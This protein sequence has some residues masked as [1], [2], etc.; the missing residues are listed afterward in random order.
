M[1]FL[2]DFHRVARLL[3]GKRC[4][5][6]W[7]A[8]LYTYPPKNHYVANIY[9]KTDVSIFA[10]AKSKIVYTGKFNLPDDREIEMMDVRWK[11]F[12]FS[13]QIPKK[14]QWTMPPC[15]KCFADLVLYE[16]M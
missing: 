5:Y 12:E 4:C 2:N 1:I 7:Q 10:M 11:F 8:K 6:Y 16:R 14:D 3:L 15:K 9:I 13:H